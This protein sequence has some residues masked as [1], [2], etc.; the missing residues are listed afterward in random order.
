MLD[1]AFGLTDTSRLGCQVQVTREMDGTDIT[2]PAATRNMFVDGA[3]ILM[4]ALCGPHEFSREKISPSLNKWETAV[5]D[6][7]LKSTAICFL[8]I[9]EIMFI[10]QSVRSTQ[11]PQTLM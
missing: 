5:C 3:E 11:P 6:Q 2:L 8:K 1:M 7:M 10:N 4:I 9:T